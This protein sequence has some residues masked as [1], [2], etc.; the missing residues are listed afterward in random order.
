MVKNEV[1]EAYQQQFSSFS[2][3]LVKKVVVFDSVDSTN[4]LAK[5]YAL[6]G[7]AEG[8]VVVALSQS[9]GRGRFDRRWVSPFGGLYCSVVL[10]PKVEQKFFSLLPLVSSVAL[11]QSITDFFDLSLS[12]KWPND[13]MVGPCKL[14]GILLEASKDKNGDDFVVLGLGLNVNA[15]SELLGLNRASVSLSELIGLDIDVI[16]CFVR[17]FTALEKWYGRFCMQDFESVL[18][19]WR[20][21]SETLGHQVSVDRGRD[22]IKGVAVD[23]DSFGFLV[24]SLD[25]GSEVKLSS[26]DVSYSFE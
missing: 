13:V 14:A 23:V 16:S 3:N 6:E 22:V 17:F 18:S 8:C 5:D 4:K 15:R 7:E 25:D 19:F 9:G 10:R 26:G 2:N 20:R 11:Y 12:I 1:F 24:V 21:H